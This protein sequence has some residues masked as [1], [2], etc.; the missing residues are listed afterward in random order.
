[1]DFLKSMAIAAAG[2]RSQAGR[3]RVISENLA[4]AEST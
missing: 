2:L 4:N 1:M 3:M